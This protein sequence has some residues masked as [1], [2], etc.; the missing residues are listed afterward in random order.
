[1]SVEIVHPVPVDDLNGW[2]ASLRTALLAPREG[3]VAEAWA[4]NRRQA[5][6]PEFAWGVRDRDTWVGSLIAEPRTITVP[7]AH[8]VGTN[9]LA[10]DAVTAVSVAAT[11][12]RRGLLRQMITQ[13]QQA[14][15]ERGDP[16]SVLIA[17][18]WGI[19]GRYG[20]APAVAG[21][22]YTYYPRRRDAAPVGGPPVGVRQVTSTQLAA[23]APDLW[24]RLRRNRAG[25]LDR[26]DPWWPRNL[27]RDG[28]RGMFHPEPAW[29]LR[30]DADGRADGVLGWHVTA[31]SDLEGNVGAGVVDLLAAATDKAY[32]ELWA[33]L[34]GI[35]LVGAFELDVRPVDEPVRWLLGDGRALQ[36]R[37][38]TDEVWLRLLDVPAAL[39]ARGYAVDD[40]L[41]LE[42]EDPDGYADGRFAVSAS[43]GLGTCERTGREPDLRL[44][45]RALASAYLGGYRLG[46]LA[47]TGEIE[48]LTP[49]ALTRADRLLATATPPWNQTHF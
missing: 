11:H 7:G 14:A 47:I 35:D 41:V 44:P 19:Y 12:R 46:A 36:T 29:V 6:R 38:V 31:D 30:E 5:W 10:A 32:R 24:E 4:H 26:S 48:E 39:A 45:Q 43:G 34:A 13:S 9:L 49:G 17:A 33:Y 23:V 8:G 1:M 3:P 2:L 21:A 15:A 37:A 16:V 25:Q 18:E 27:G 40:E 28:F 20:Y 42:V 22:R